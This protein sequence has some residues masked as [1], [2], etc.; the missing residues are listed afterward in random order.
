MKT[1]IIGG[2]GLIGA[3][4]ARLMN[5]NGH[6]ITRLEIAPIIQPFLTIITSL[7]TISMTI[8]Q[9]MY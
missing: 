1:L 4:I 2:T 6:E 5:S 3:E 9:L 8:F 7:M